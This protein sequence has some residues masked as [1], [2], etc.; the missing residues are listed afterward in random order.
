M[1]LY[2]IGLVYRTSRPGGV[3]ISIST[4]CLSREH[5]VV[6]VLLI[7]L[8]LTASFMEK[9]TPPQRYTL[10][11]YVQSEVSPTKAEKLASQ[12]CIWASNCASERTHVE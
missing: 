4:P 9:Q 12:K 6:I 11:V 2:V 8:A 7:W 5:A 1:R 3:E 10:L